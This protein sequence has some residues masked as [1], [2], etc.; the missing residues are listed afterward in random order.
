[1]FSVCCYAQLAHGN[2]LCFIQYIHM[3]WGILLN[4]VLVEEINISTT[5][6]TRILTSVRVSPLWL[7][8]RLA[9]VPAHTNS[10]YL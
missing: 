6:I 2:K 10:S 5:Q 4:E 9:Q 3:D 1:M 8:E 7:L